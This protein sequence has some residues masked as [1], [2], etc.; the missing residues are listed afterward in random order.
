[1]E[2]REKAKRPGKR[3][4]VW[5][6]I[7]AVVVIAAVIIAVQ[8]NRILNKPAEL[9]ATEP[10]AVTPQVVEVDEPE[11]EPTPEPEPSPEVTPEPSPDATH[12]PETAAPE[13]LPG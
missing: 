12:A 5:L 2:R 13:N 9:F 3:M 7:L 8:A 4:L 11:Q 10:P 6:I 1:M